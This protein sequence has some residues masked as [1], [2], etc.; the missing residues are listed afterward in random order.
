M[1]ILI[2][3]GHLAPALAVIDGI[4][5]NKELSKTTSIVFVGRKYAQY[6]DKKPT[7]EYQEITSRN[8][9]FF[10]LKAGRLNRSVSIRSLA[11]VMRV[12]EGFFQAYH[13]LNKEK[14]DI[15]LSFGGYLALPVAVVSRLFGIPVYTHEQTVHP[16]LANRLIAAFAQKVFI[17]FPQSRKYFP[18]RK[19]YMSG[20]PVRKQIHENKKLS[21]IPSGRGKIIYITG[22]SLGSHSINAHIEEILNAL[23]S[24]YIVI[25]QTGNVTEFDDFNR[26]TKVRNKLPPELKERYVLKEHI[27]SYENGGVY[28][29]ADLVISRAGANTF[30]DLIALKKPAILIPLP[31][32]ANGEQEKQAK[33]LCDA[34]AAEIFDQA[35][36]SDHLLELVDSMMGKLH[37]YEEHYAQLSGIYQKD[38]VQTIIQTIFKTA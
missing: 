22:G 37:D 20:N 10:H 19:I 35:D 30:F 21:Y 32:S 16:G 13:I 34:Q 4:R 5:E 2:T 31:W 11:G 33:I 28:K 1:K 23:L 6:T 18:R 29:A 25:H 17:S 26:L 12:P 14:P 38:A 15:V 24:R 8:I 9:P 36:T 27:P 7:L 3:G